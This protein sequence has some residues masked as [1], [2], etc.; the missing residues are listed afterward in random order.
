M[1]ATALRRPT[2]HPHVRG[3]SPALRSEIPNLMG[4]PPRAWGQRRPRRVHS[5]AF[6]FTPTCVGT[7]EDVSGVRL[8]QE[9]HPHVRGDSA[10]TRSHTTRL[11]G[12]PPRA[13]GQLRQKIL[14][15]HWPGF[16]PTCV[17]TASTAGSTAETSGVHPHV[18]GDSGRR[19]C[20]QL[21]GRGSP[22]RA[23]GQ[24]SSVRVSGNWLRF[25]PTCVGTASTQP[26]R[27]RG[28]RVHPHVRGDS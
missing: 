16:T 5:W 25:T 4:S 8:P 20:K 6:G 18:R 21:D 9:V 11:S 2:V 13:W 15:R 19:D 24:P 26:R 22:P 3:D 17:G 28:L 23:W 27:W 12:S 7:A 1:S 10:L 14:K